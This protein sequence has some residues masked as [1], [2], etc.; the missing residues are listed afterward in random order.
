M[1]T[2]IATVVAALFSVL[3]LTTYAADEVK[4]ADQPTDKPAAME[5]KHHGK[6]HHEKH[7]EEH[8]EGAAAGTPDKK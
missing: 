2:L 6:K 3:A 5:K 8:K 7:H 4:P 1:K